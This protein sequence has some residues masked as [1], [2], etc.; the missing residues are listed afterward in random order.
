MAKAKAKVPLG[1]GG[2]KMPKIEPQT[3]AVEQ[4]QVFVADESGEAIQGTVES[5]RADWVA[6]AQRCTQMEKT[7]A[8][9]AKVNHR[10]SVTAVV[11]AVAA[12][13]CSIANGVYLV[14]EAWS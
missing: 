14:V 3:V 2:T 6:L 11:L 5:L 10:C 12:F 13:A 8:A 7:Q 9:D 4:T 1:Q